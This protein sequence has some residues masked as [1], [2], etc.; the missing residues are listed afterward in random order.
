M[1]HIIFTD[2]CILNYPCTPRINPSY[3]QCMILLMCCLTQFVRISWILWIFSISMHQGYL[4]VI[5]LV[6]LSS[7]WY[8]SNTGFLKL[9]WKCLPLQISGSLKICCCS[10]TQSCPTLCDPMDCSMPGLPV[11]HHLLEFTQVHVLFISDAIQPSHLLL[12]SFP[13]AFILFQHQGS[14]V[15]NQLINFFLLVLLTCSWLNCCFP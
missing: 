14:F 7:F 11:L 4:P 15:F 10:I 1:W 13:S 6:S 5:F 2:L 3:S 8:K 12:P 9:V